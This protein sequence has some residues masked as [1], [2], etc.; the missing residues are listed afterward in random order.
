LG[1]QL[2]LLRF[3]LDRAAG[4][5]GGYIV[6]LVGNNHPT[7]VVVVNPFFY[8]TPGHWSNHFLLF[9]LP[10]LYTTLLVKDPSDPAQEGIA[11]MGFFP[12]QMAPSV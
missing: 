6:I 1:W 12:T 5:V 7:E 3:A 8:C 10:L 2:D 11:L 9:K 4:E